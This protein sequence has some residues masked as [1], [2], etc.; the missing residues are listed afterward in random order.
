MIL[1]EDFLVEQRKHYLTEALKFLEEKKIL[2]FSGGARFGQVVFLAGGAGSGKGV[3]QSYLDIKDFKVFD[4]D[5]L[6]KQFLKL[7]AATGKHPEIRGLDLRRADDVGKLHAYIKK[8]GIIDAKL[9]AFFNSIKN[10]RGNLPNILFDETLKDLDNLNTVLPRLLELGYKPEN[11]NIVWILADYAVAVTRNKTR[12]RVVPD[13]ILLK[14]HEGAA[15]TMYDIIRGNIPKGVNGSIGV[16]LNNERVVINYDD[17]ATNASAA[18]AQSAIVMKKIVKDKKG[19][20]KELVV[21]KDFP[22]ISIKDQGAA[23]KN[24]KDVQQQVFDWMMGNIPKTALTGAAMRSI[25]TK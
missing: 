23:I 3:S 5:E 21:V 4:V 6:K 12:D 8:L 13:D 7:A 19:E 10:G 14:T 9:D 20:T 24:E 22:Y 15:T 25:V 17:P 18:T 11:I 1:F 2:Q 16:I